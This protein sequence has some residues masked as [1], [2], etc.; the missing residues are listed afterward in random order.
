MWFFPWFFSFEFSRQNDIFWNTVFHDFEGFEQFVMLTRQ[1]I[2]EIAILDVAVHFNFPDFFFWKIKC[3][4]HS[5]ILFYFY[6][7]STATLVWYLHWSTL[8][9]K[10]SFCTMHLATWSLAQRMW[11]I[12]WIF[13]ICYWIERDFGDGTTLFTL[14]WHKVQTGPK[15][16][17]GKKNLKV[18]I[19]PKKKNIWKN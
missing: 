17:R 8:L 7:K 16:F 5:R 19:S 18:S 4:W 12:L 3:K 10:S 14:N 15:S 9:R 2:R 1:K 13:K 11:T 6:R